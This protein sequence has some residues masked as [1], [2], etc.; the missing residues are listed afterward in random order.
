MVASSTSTAQTAAGPSSSGVSGSSSLHADDTPT[1]FGGTVASSSTVDAN[2]DQ[3][4][5]DFFNFSSMPTSSGAGSSAASRGSS[6]DT[7]A[8]DAMSSS[9]DSC[10]DHEMSN[11]GWSVT[12]T[13]GSP[14]ACAS[15][16]TADTSAAGASHFPSNHFSSLYREWRDGGSSAI[17]R[18]SDDDVTWECW[19]PPKSYSKQQ[20]TSR[21]Y[22]VV[23]NGDH[24]KRKKASPV[25]F[26][27]DEEGA[28]AAGDDV[29]KVGKRKRRFREEVA[30][31][32]TAGAD[33][34]AET[35]AKTV[36]DVLGCSKQPPSKKSAE[37]WNGELSA[38]SCAYICTA[39]H[40]VSQNWAS[41]FC[42]SNVFSV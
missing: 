37:E 22:T 31:S 32:A 11:A 17:D 24:K 28:A 18:D 41:E 5:S 12:S 21:P 4:S 39:M 36:S 35:S 6:M 13:R 3:S 1:N 7:A 26:D 10:N 20:L 27:S 29:A 15:T 30:A 19:S 16:A 38:V 23:A 2:D 40:N 34:A 33:A 9:H 42:G 25:I 8:W 14:V